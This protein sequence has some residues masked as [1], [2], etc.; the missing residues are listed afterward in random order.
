MHIIYKKLDQISISSSLAEVSEFET[1]TIKVNPLVKFQNSANPG[2]RTIEKLT[3]DAHN[4]RRGGRLSE[5][6]MTV[7]E[8]T[9]PRHAPLAK[10]NCLMQVEVVFHIRGRASL[11]LDWNSFLNRNHGILKLLAVD[12]RY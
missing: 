12:C 5:L 7:C 1:K 6:E 8:R 11:S 4:F 10:G 2:P 9:L 3:Y